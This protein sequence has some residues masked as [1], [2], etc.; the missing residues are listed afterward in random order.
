MRMIANTQMY[1]Y[2][3]YSHF[4]VVACLCVSEKKACTLDEL[5]LFLRPEG[6][7][8]LDLAGRKLKVG[9]VCLLLDEKL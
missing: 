9:S 1:T 3:A 7:L 2:P 6:V 4:R 5:A 8:L